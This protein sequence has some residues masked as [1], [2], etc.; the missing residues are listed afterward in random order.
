MEVLRQSLEAVE[1]RD[2]I[3]PISKGDRLQGSL[4]HARNRKDD[5]I[6]ALRE[7]FAAGGMEAILETSS[8]RGVQVRAR[9]RV[10][11]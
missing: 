6:E 4:L 9:L 7:R 1:T 2:H 11:L 10:T 3:I 5:E 8:Q